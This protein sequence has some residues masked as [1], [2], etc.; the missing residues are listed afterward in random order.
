MAKNIP[1]LPYTEIVERVSS[2]TRSADNTR[3][4]VRGVVQDVYVREIPTKFDWNFLMTGSS[5]TTT[6][7]SNTGTVTATTGST[8]ITFSGF[9][10]TASLTGQKIKFTGNDV[11]YNYTHVSASAG[12]VTPA[13]RGTAN[14]SAGS[15]TIFQ[16]AYPLSLDFDRFPKNG[17]FYKWQG[18]RK[19]LVREYEY[20]EWT[21]EYTPSPST[22]VS[23]MRVYGTNTVG[24]PL[25]ELNPPPSDARILSYDYMRRLN[26]MRENTAGLLL[27]IGASGTSVLGNPGTTKFMDS[28][29]GDFLRVDALG[30]GQDSQWY[31]I[32]SI[33]HDSS[34]TLATAFANTAITSSANYTIAS[35]PEM[36]HKLHYGVLYGA[37]RSISFDQNDEA[38]GFYQ[39]KFGEVMSDGKKQYVT[40]D[41]SP[42]IDTLA[43][44]WMYRR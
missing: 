16:E 26:P 14:I 3:E 18:G 34:L 22:T 31:R 25:V 7:Q 4:K 10:S 30:I 24:V 37:I 20:R 28:N 13:F 44:D 36:P 33:T 1:E 2:L 23:R 8:S 15:F 42:D 29:T 19:E 39:I 21:D 43:T 27:S 9:T 6:A 17:G 41:Y 5:L 38:A 11:V 12:T 35:A 32:I 40:R